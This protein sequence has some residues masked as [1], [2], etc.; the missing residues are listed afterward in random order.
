MRIQQSDGSKCYNRKASS[1]ILRG[2]SY[3]GFSLPGGI[4]VGCI[5]E[6]AIPLLSAY[7]FDSCGMQDVQSTLWRHLTT[8]LP[9]GFATQSA[10]ASKHEADMPN[11]PSIFLQFFCRIFG[12]MHCGHLINTRVVGISRGHKEQNQFGFEQNIHPAPSC[13]VRKVQRHS[14]ANTNRDT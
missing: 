4:I 11:E 6:A 8:E 3:R 1:A 12:R 10:T 2:F 13:K 14:E 9:N 5:S 7:C